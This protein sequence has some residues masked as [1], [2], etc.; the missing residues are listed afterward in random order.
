MKKRIS[1][2]FKGKKF[3]IYARKC[4]IFNSGLMFRSSRTQPCLFEF[5]KPS[6]FKITSLFVFH[7]FAAVWLDNKNKILDIK[8]V[9]PF[10]F[11]ISPEKP[12]NK[13]LEIPSGNKNFI[14]FNPRRRKI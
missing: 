2:S 14:F 10:T 11:E 1:F 8:I 4:G 3:S 5:N 9:N 12:F 7:T 6:R 13:L